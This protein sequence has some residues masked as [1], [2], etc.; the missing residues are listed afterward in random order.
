M[1][2]TKLTATDIKTDLIKD[3]KLPALDWD[4]LVFGHSFSDHMFSVDFK[5]GQWTEATIMPYQ[6]LDMSPALMALHYGQSIFEGMKAYRSPE[7]DILLFRPEENWKRLNASAE[8]MSMQQIP[9]EVFIDGLMTLLQQD[10]NWVP[11]KEG[12]SLYIRPFMFATDSYIGVRPSDTY[13][14]MII[15]CPVGAY[16]AKPVKVKVEKQYVRAAEGGVGFAKAAGNYA[17]ALKPTRLAVEQGYDQ[18]LWTDAK[19]HKYFEESGTMNVMFVIDDILITP[20]LSGSIL[21]GITRNSVLRLVRDW[22][23]TVEERRVPVAEVMK[24]A[25]EGRLQEA[26]G[27]GTAATITH[28]ATIGHE[29]TDYEL[30]KVEDRELSHKILKTLNSMRTGKAEDTYDWNLSLKDYFN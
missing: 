10:Q 15:T 17:A 5:D 23:I 13:K 18:L 25:Q 1:H 2:T 20:R 22:G 11:D 3:S 27:V 26:F 16:Y 24:A 29:G 6:N 21:P 14:F 9:K 30:P 4:K 7:G 12:Y 8:R 28:I 19:E